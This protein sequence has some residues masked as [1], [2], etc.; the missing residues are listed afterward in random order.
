MQQ[1]LSEI[2]NKLDLTSKSKIKRRRTHLMVTSCDCQLLTLFAKETHISVICTVVIDVSSLRSWLRYN[3]KRKAKWR[4]TRQGT[5]KQ[6]KAFQD[7]S[8][9]G[10]C[11]TNATRALV[12]RIHSQLW[13][14]WRFLV[15]WSD[16]W[17]KEILTPPPTLLSVWR[18][19]K[20][21][22]NCE[23]SAWETTSATLGTGTSSLC[24]E[25]NFHNW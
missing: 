12:V 2:M 13:S 6:S 4:P 22:G 17:Y 7:Q 18:I 5:P 16:C 10:R 23:P 25:R 20:P 1:V 8:V 11:Q 15:E 9:F 3:S 21:A 24:D 14:K 19:P